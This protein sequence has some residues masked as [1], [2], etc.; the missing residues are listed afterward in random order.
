MTEILVLSQIFNITCEHGYIGMGLGIRLIKEDYNFNSVDVP[1][2]ISG[3]VNYV[4][5]PKVG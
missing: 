3:V 1:T 5:K 2:M 4:Y